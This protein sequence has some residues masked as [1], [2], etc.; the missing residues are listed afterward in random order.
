METYIAK[1]IAAFK[2]MNH[3]LLLVSTSATVLRV[4]I[5]QQHVLHAF[6]MHS[7]APGMFLLIYSVQSDIVSPHASCHIPDIYMHIVCI[8]KCSQSHDV[9]VEACLRKHCVGMTHRS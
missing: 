1:E 6:C 4:R 3:T 9:V 2:I 5:Q 7:C 8:N